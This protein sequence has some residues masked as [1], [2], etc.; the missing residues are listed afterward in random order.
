MMD[1]IDDTEGFGIDER[2]GVRGNN[3]RSAFICDASAGSSRRVVM[4]R[5][6]PSL[7]AR[8]ESIIVCGREADHTT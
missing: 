7:L 6:G 5:N 4:A 8:S 2:D 3:G 1:C